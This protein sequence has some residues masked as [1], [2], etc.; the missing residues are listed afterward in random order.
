MVTVHMDG[1]SINLPDAVGAKDE[2]VRAALAPFVPWIANA[3]IERKEQEG[4]TVL[5]IIKRADTKGS[6]ADV[7]A[8]LIAAPEELNPAVALWKR[9]ERAANLDNPGTILEWQPAIADAI[10]QGEREIELVRSTLVQLA[11]GSV[12]RTTRVPLG[13]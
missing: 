5:N 4:Q 2:L 7:L 12:A 10:Q 11:E 9:L 3:Q 13:F 1:Q 6:G 8:A